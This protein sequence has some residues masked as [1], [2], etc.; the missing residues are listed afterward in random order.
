MFPLVMYADDVPAVRRWLLPAEAGL[1]ELLS[2]VADER[3]QFA[4]RNQEV[5]RHAG[6]RTSLETIAQ[7]AVFVRQAL[8]R[9]IQCLGFVV[10]FDI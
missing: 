10:D 3:P 8:H 6:S 2:E 9:V 4:A 1:L 7:L 5:P